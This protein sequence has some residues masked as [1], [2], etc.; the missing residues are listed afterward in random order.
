MVDNRI[1]DLQEIA[2]T[3]ALD[4]DEI[5]KILASM[6]EKCELLQLYPACFKIKPGDGCPRYGICNRE[7]SGIADKSA[8]GTLTVAELKKRL[9]RIKNITS[10]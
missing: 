8:H 9:V 3:T 7:F 10:L 6:M 1:F 4:S 2:S 5:F